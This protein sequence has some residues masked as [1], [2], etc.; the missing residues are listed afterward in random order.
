MADSFSNKVFLNLEIDFGLNCFNLIFS[1]FISA[2][3]DFVASAP[4]YFYIIYL[5]LIV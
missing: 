5:K 4:I 1:G 2:R 3:D